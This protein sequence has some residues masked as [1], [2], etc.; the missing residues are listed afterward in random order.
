MDPIYNLFLRENSAASV[1]VALW[2]HLGSVAGTIKYVTID[3]LSALVR[4]RGVL[5]T[6][7][8]MRGR[9]AKLENQRLIEMVPS[10]DRGVYDC[11]VFAP[12]P[13]RDMRPKPE[14]PQPIIDLIEEAEKSQ[15]KK[16][17][18]DTAGIDRDFHFHF[19]F[20]NENEI[21]LKAVSHTQEEYNKKKIKEI[22][23]QDYAEGVEASDADKPASDD[24]E[25][26]PAGAVSAGDV[27]SVID[28]D[29]VP[30]ART[31]SEVARILYEDTIHPD[32]VDRA[33]AAIVLEIGGFTVQQLRRINSE[34]ELEQNLYRDT[35][36]R[37]GKKYRWMITNLRLKRLYRLH[38]W[39]YPRTTLGYEISP[40]TQR[41]EESQSISAEAGTMSPAS[42]LEK[43]ETIAEGF[44]P[45]DLDIPLVD[46]ARRIA[47]PG[48]S[49]PSAFGRAACIVNA[50][51][52]IYKPVGV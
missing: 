45:A 22:K 20:E 16:S 36:G 21:G 47:K 34:A 19:H 14:P 32:V 27:R 42:E 38:G 24:G 37:R 51:K 7:S 41:Q 46:F 3:S 33:T 18:V 9:L 12:C 31:R 6:L 26:V 8:Q 10:N 44:G 40:F 43:L 39:A 2:L 13:E 52:K 29:S 25:H 5:V 49:Q 4:S 17:V 48:E 15:R 23:K 50:L 28:F 35:D 11:Y 1:Y 30:V